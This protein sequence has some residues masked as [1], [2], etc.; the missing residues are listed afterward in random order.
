MPTWKGNL[1]QLTRKYEEWLEENLSRELTQLSQKEHRHFFGT[2]NSA[3]MLVSR[4]LDLFRNLLEKNIENAL[5]AKLPPAEWDISVPEPAHPDV[6]STKV[7]DFHFDLLWF[8][9][10]M[11]IFRGVFERRFFRKIPDIAQMH[12]SRLAYQWEIRINRTIEKIKEQALRYVR[13]ELATI[14]ALLS[15]TAG[16][17]DDIRAALRDLEGGLT[18]LKNREPTPGQTD[19]VIAKQ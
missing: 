14:D 2:L 9:I 1:W 8:V 19:I 3:Y 4:S 7:F 6:A 15:R 16:Q 11:T 18:T 5:G 12:L 13:E 10:P 17:T